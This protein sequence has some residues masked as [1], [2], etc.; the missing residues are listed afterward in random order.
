[1]E[2]LFVFVGMAKAAFCPSAEQQVRKSVVQCSS[3]E[4]DLKLYKGISTA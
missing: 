4:D 1:M 2:S 3:R